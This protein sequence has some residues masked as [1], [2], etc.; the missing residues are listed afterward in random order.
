MTENEKQLKS[1]RY[2]RGYSFRCDIIFASL[3]LRL[4]YSVVSMP[5]QHIL[6]SNIMKYKK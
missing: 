1:I 6:K 5:P 4:I 2:L 3:D